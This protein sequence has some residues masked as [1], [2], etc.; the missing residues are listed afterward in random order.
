ADA[1]VVWADQIENQVRVARR[2]VWQQ[3][4][5]HPA[6]RSRQ[7][8]DAHVVEGHA[9]SEPARRREN[10]DGLVPQRDG[11]LKRAVCAIATL[12]SRTKNRRR[13]PSGARTGRAAAGVDARERRR[14]S[15]LLRR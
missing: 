15:E 12:G 8:E 2:S 9:E 11:F 13:Y 6:P 5:G 4:R 3:L 1:R 7:Y 14:R 10:F